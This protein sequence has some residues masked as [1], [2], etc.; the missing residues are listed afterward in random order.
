[1]HAVVLMLPARPEAIREVRQRLRY[2]LEAQELLNQEQIADLLVMVS[3]AATN[4]LRHG[5]DQARDD[6]QLTVAVRLV[7]G[8]RV[9][10]EVTDPGTGTAQKPE[11]GEEDE[12]G[13]G[14]QII[15]EL[16]SAYGAVYGEEGARTTWF[17]LPARAALP[18]PTD[19]DA[20]AGRGAVEGYLLEAPPKAVPTQNRRASARRA[21]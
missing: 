4:G 8:A 10:V 11:P 16:S 17:E 5:C 2:V 21:A 15:A 6:E 9:R 12:H 14:L 7:D 1:M 18:D 20:T 13:R 3:E 19:G